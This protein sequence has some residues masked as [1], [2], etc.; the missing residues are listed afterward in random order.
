[1]AP[2]TPPSSP[3]TPLAS[4]PA[5]AVSARRGAALGPERSGTLR[6]TADPEAVVSI[7]GEGLHQ[8]RTTPVR[9][10]ALKPG[11][12][13]ITFRNGTYGPPVAAPV[14]VTT[15]SARSVHVDF[16]QVEPRVTVR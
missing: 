14:T 12:Y 8:T 10:L 9:S 7:D 1:M 16:R 11:T 3:P 13:R 6:L 5:P 2:A 15:G 4:V